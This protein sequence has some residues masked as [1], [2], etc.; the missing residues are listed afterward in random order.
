MPER[1]PSQP[2]ITA[3]DVPERGAPE[4]GWESQ[5]LLDRA[6]AAEFDLPAETLAG[7][8]AK[9]FDEAGRRLTELSGAIARGDAVSVAEAAH[10]LSGGSGTL[11]VM[12]VAE[13]ASTLDAAAEA[14]DLSSA[15]RL[16]D[17]L[18]SELLATEESYRRT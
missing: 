9:Y 18:R 4:T 11:G 13:L 1:P 10:T 7:L 16:L 2:E 3:S 5:P 8:F 17:R 14:G 6:V 15:P 12:R